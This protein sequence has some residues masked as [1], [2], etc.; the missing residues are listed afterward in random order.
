IVRNVWPSDL[1]GPPG[2]SVPPALRRPRVSVGRSFQERVAIRPTRPT[3][4]IRPTRPQAAQRVSGPLFSGTCG[5]PTYPA[6][7]AY[8][9]H[10]TSSG[11]ACQWAALFSNVWPSY[12]PG[13][14]S[15]SVPPALTRP[16]ASVC[17]SFQDRASVVL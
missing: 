8:P 17:R 1:R 10:L 9:S 5:R 12:L 14:P 4:L 3:R 16:S 13:P 15:L 2:L 6:H 11:P 7:P